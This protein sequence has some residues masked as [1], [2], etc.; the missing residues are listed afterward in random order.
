[1]SKF[2]FKYSSVKK[3][4]ENFERKAQKELAQIDLFIQ[5]QE[6][7][8]Q[9][10]IDEINSL[11]NNKTKKRVCAA[12]L[13]FAGGYKNCVIKKI[14]SVDSEL[15][16][17]TNKRNQKLDEVLQ[18]SK[19]KKVLNKLE[20]IHIDNFLKESNQIETKELDEIAVQKFSRDK[21]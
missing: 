13:I 2:V 18:K 3:I 17:L 5:Q 6:K 21:K 12:D 8:K 7:L 11:R 15:N 16:N 20:E 4:K 14:E 19:E 10:L 9:E 1:M